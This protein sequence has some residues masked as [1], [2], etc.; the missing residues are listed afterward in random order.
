M[1]LRWSVSLRLTAWFGGIFFLG[2]LLFGIAMWW[3]LKSTLVTERYGTLARREHRL[4]ML[5]ART[6]DESRLDRARKFAAFAGATGHGLSEVLRADSDQPFFPPTAT[7]RQFPWPALRTF[8]AE[9]FEQVGWSGD[10]YWVLGRPFSLGGEKLYLVAAAPEA[11]NELVLGRFLTVLLA[12]I[13]ILLVVASAGGYFLSRRALLPVDRITASARSTS[14]TNLSERVPVPQT[15]DELQRLAE[16]CNEMLARLEASVRRIRQFTADASHDL[17][18]P[19]SF[20]RT[21]AEVALRDPGADPNS[22]RA[23]ADIVDESAKASVLLEDLL[24]LARADSDR[25]ELAL[26]PV[27]LCR[28]VEEACEVA[29]PLAM[30]RQHSLS[31]DVNGSKE[32]RVLGDFASLRRLFWILLD[33]AVK[34]T[35]SPGRIEVSLNSSPHEIVVTI[36]DNGI[37][38]PEKDLPRVFDRFYRADPSRGQ[39]EGSGLGLSI[40]KWLAD[41]HRARLSVASAVNSGT[42]FEVAFPAYAC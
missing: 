10:E 26:A 27:N 11:G 19:I 6:R 36:R 9:K 28:V 3:S 14:I 32:T 35:P 38:I 22:R 42:T 18:G 29:R 41:S 37:G 17:R 24:T 25:A 8:D 39:V 30:E 13:P 16:T 34:Y 5:L 31:V 15:G 40:A 20:V 2:S 12:S 33:N 23:L 7:A 21:V 1:T 4:E